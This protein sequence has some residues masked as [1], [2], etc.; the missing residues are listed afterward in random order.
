MFH[1]GNRCVCLGG[2]KRRAAFFV[3]PAHVGMRQS[4]SVCELEHFDIRLISCGRCYE[5]FLMGSRRRRRLLEFR[6]SVRRVAIT[7]RCVF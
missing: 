7:C 6:G 4:T 2:V 1:T 3:K 5:T